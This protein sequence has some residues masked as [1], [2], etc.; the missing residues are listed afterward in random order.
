[1]E[2]TEQTILF[3]TLSLQNERRKILRAATIM[4]IL[5]SSLIRCLKV[6]LLG[7]SLTFTLSVQGEDVEKANYESEMLSNLRGAGRI[8]QILDGGIPDLIPNILPPIIPPL[9][10]I[11]PPLPPIIPFTPTIPPIHFPSVTPMIPPAVS[12]GDGKFPPSYSP[13]V[14]PG[15]QPPVNSPGEVDGGYQPSDIPRVYMASDIPSDSSSIVPSDIPTT[16]ILTSAPVPGPGPFPIR[17]CTDPTGPIS[18]FCDENNFPLRSCTDPSPVSVYCLNQNGIPEAREPTSMSP[19]LAPIED[20]DDEE[21]QRTASS[22]NITFQY[23][24]RNVLP[25]IMEKISRMFKGFL[26]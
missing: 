7:F 18:V 25:R 19:S 23:F 16:L 11:I 12:E 14:T 9:P 3:Q 8:L 20:P 21:N 1:M 13:S 6:F 22:S 24:I 17:N 2:Y 26:N 4:F 5:S 15:I 10:P